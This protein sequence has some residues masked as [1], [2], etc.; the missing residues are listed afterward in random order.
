MHLEHSSG[1]CIILRKKLLRDSSGWSSCAL[2]CVVTWQNNIAITVDQE[3]EMTEFS[4][5]LYC[6]R[7]RSAFFF[8]RAWP[9]RLPTAARRFAGADPG[10]HFRDRC[11]AVYERGSVASQ[12]FPLLVK[13]CSSRYF[14]RTVS[15]Y[16]EYFYG[17]CRRVCTIG[18]FVCKIKPLRE[19]RNKLR[20][21]GNASAWACC[22]ATF[23][24]LAES[25]KSENS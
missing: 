19:S 9:P 10:G 18:W 5:E 15:T 17:K 16:A 3:S 20:F 23:C 2:S 12:V 6:K 13:S 21:V 11:C 7:T 25:G 4:R 8:F 22:F 1:M 14:G 24:A